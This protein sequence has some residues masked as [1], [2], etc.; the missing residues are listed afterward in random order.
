MDISFIIDFLFKNS[1]AIILG[2]VIGYERQSKKKP[3]GVKTHALICIG[4]C[5]ICFLSRYFSSADISDPS[6]IAAQIVSGIGFIGAG[7]IFVSHQ[8]IKG[9]TSAATVWV[10]ASI[11]ML[12]GAGY[13]LLGIISVGLIECL[14]LFFYLTRFGTSDSFSITI[15]SEQ[16]HLLDQLQRLNK[17]YGIEP[18]NFSLDQQNSDQGSRFT[19]KYQFASSKLIQRLYTRRLSQ[20]QSIAGFS[21]QTR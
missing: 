7:T 10:S 17:H 20:L 4:A 19:I 11:G 16:A 2:A 3:A 21:I 13:E 12:I 14:F 8:R 1:L 9:L 5:S 6:R 15:H 18:E